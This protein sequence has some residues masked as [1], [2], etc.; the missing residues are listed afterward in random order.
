MTNIKKEAVLMLFVILGIVSSIS[1]IAD[2]VGCCINPGAA[3]RTCSSQ[4]LVLKNADCCP[5]PE[6]NFP[7]YYKSSQNQELPVDYND[8]AANF[9]FQNKD[10]SSIG[11][12]AI[13][14][15]C[16]ESG[17]TIKPE[18]QCKG[19]G[20]TFYK[21]G[22][23]C[24]EI[25]PAPK[26]QGNSCNN[27]NSGCAN[28]NYNPKL[29]NFEVIPVKG[30]KK[31]S[32]KWQDECSATAISYDILRC[33]ENGCANFELVGTSYI[34]SFE[35]SS[36]D[37]LFDSEYTYQVKSKYHLQ[38][39]TPTI[40]KIA[41][42]GDVEC[43]S[44]DTA[45]KFCVHAPYYNRYKD[46]LS[47]NFPEI[48][49]SNFADGVKNKFGEKFNRAFFCDSTNK[50]IPEGT[51]CSS[52][53]ICV[54][55]NNLPACLNKV[56][57]NYNSANP[58]GLFYTL[59]G[60]ENNR[61]CFYD[62]S[63]STVDSC[64]SCDPSMSCYDYKTKEACTRD[65]CKI[66]NCKWKNLA[67]QIGIGAC[68]STVDY[69]CK[70]CE[71]KGT[72]SLENLK[73]FNDVFDLC[74]KEKS[75]ILS[76]GAF[77]CYYRNQKSK[78]CNEVVCRDYDKDQ[79]SNLQ[80]SHDENN[81]IKNPSLDECNIKVC[82]NI[83]N[84]CV[85]NADGDDKSD[86]SD[87][88]CESDYFAPNT[89]LLPSIKKGAV[90]KLIIQ[91]SDKTSVNSSYILKTTPDY[92]TFLCVEPCGS[93]G[94][95]F[96]TLT[97]SRSIILSNLNAYDGDNGSKIFSLNE[98]INVL[99]YYSQDPAKNIE[100]VKKITIGVHNNTDGPKILN[101]NITDGSKILDKYYTSNQQ[102]KITVQFV[103]P[104]IVTQSSLINTKTGLAAPLEGNT[105]LSTLVE[106]LVMQTLPNGE[107]NFELNAKN[108]NNIFMDTQFSANIV[109]DNDKP[110]VTIT[111]DNGAVLN[112]SSVNIK[113]E[114]NKEV[115]LQTVKINEDIITNLFST[116]DNKV[117][118]A[119]K[120]LSDGNKKLEVA[121]TDYAKNKVVSYVRFIVD[122]NPTTI[123][124]I[125][126][127]FGTASSFVF[128]IGVSTDNDAVCRF[129]FDNNFEF[130]F[131]DLF[132][133]TG[134][135]LH[136]I[137]NF[138]RISNGDI[139]THKLFVKCK[140]NRYGITANS[141]DINVD[142]TAPQLKTL[143]AYPNPVVE[144]PSN[145]TLTVESNEPV[146]CK[147]SIT[148]NQFENMERKFDG[149]NESNFR[150]IN[151]AQVNFNNEGTFLFFVAC[152]NKAEIPSESKEISVKV[153]ST[154]PLSV[155]SHTLAYSSSTDIA[156]AIETNKKSQCKFSDNDPTVQNGELFGSPGYAHT[157][158]LTL[159]QGKYTYYV[160]CK[161]Q[162]L[163]KFS[164]VLPVIFVIDTTPPTVLSVDDSST[165]SYNPQFTWN[166][167]SLRVKWNSVDKESGIS[168]NS[169]SLIEDGT[170]NIIVPWANSYAN[171][172]WV[173][174]TKD[175][176]TSLMLNNGT[177]YFFKV[178]AQNFVGLTSNESES[179][180]ITVDTNL[181][182]TN[183]TNKIQDEIE[184][185]IDCGGQCEQCGLGKK[186]I[187]NSDCT[188]NFCN[189][190][191]CYV[192][193][194]NDNVKNQ[195]EV[196]IDCGGKCKKCQNTRKCYTHSDCESNFCGFGTCKSQ[197]SCFDGTLTPGETD[198][199]CGGPCPTKC[200]EGKNCNSELDCQDGYVCAASICVNNKS[201]EAQNQGNNTSKRNAS[202][203][204]PE[205]KKSNILKV[206]LYTIG[207]IVLAVG[208]F[209]FLYRIRA[210]KEIEKLE[211]Q[212]QKMIRRPLPQPQVKQSD[213]RHI[214]QENK[215]RETI[216]LKE[217]QKEKE[218]KKLFETFAND[219]KPIQKEKIEQKEVYRGEPK[220]LAVQAKKEIQMGRKIKTKKPKEDAFSKLK[221]ISKETKKPKDVKHKNS[222][223]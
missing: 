153:D 15:C 46:Y 16:S 100:D 32:L 72:N 127:R 208:I 98:G 121:A 33:K 40:N 31:F 181:K 64:F 71:N 92:T 195:D 3:D 49:S 118:T 50:L 34:T 14:C 95:P 147:F 187:I 56:D 210:N 19:T 183:C 142:N 24:D 139:K 130:E 94:H 11:A 138:N 41:N 58:F 141:F 117:F 167:D 87:K 203:N 145:T 150:I 122:A 99:R 44:Q 120:N 129:S 158:S 200:S 25:C 171:N 192:A 42:L 110:T 207:A 53:Q 119:S 137:S 85:K 217:E 36:A 59:E 175:N 112:S 135:T 73:S 89:S 67:D 96:D 5:Q 45:N 155:I 220:E 48:F 176:G 162:F 151:K 101:F 17:G 215:I 8:C 204:T 185:D 123:I 79:C 160:I 54:V 168:F 223:K 206:T 221:E 37:I 214:Q 21:S 65:N 156:L 164:D 169:Y 144:K 38:G 47:A 173:L 148:S 82:Q 93:L 152:E 197:E 105:D 18:P 76:E 13:G 143:F 83:N 202:S 116:T 149:F 66:R 216:K 26:C 212:R 68:V 170:S 140:D 125:K 131:M 211:M 113:L 106:L 74:T 12:C 133:T 109:I 209:Y 163:Q 62:R 35:D 222:K 97:K 63:H 193:T 90:D 7:G 102:P 84:L 128:D 70:W 78:N 146:I 132:T 178:K 27:P 22:T 213:L 182:P 28:P 201:P 205:N 107:Y 52:D 43:S 115:K 61:Y 39:A 114:F 60:C 20:L 191:I 177:K 179:D 57:C 2:D 9:F 55:D 126:P 198:T 172:E 29:S 189:S 184:T 23:N 188:T 86:C 134:G 154:I 104:A 69:N 161:D 51:V 108:K 186:C 180:G 219:E 4:R 124:L 88:S 1:V 30:Q 157:K 81:K 10:C 6:L 174:V 103:E 196:D 190:S 75:E 199:D 77:K 111:P 194:C 166:K 165:L 80:I 91:I 159:G 136:T 218:R